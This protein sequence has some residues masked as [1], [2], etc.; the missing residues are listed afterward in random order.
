MHPH[1]GRRGVLLAD[2]VLV[3]AAQNGCH[4]SFGLIYERHAAAVRATAVARLGS[5]SMVADVVQ[6]TFARAF[7]RIHTLRDPT[8]VR[9]WL[10]QITRNAAADAYREERRSR[11]VELDAA[12]EVAD[13]RPGPTA[14]VDAA[15]ALAEIGRMI[16][17]LPP[18]DAIAMRALRASSTPAYEGLAMVLGTTPAHARVIAHRARVRLRQLLIER[19]GLDPDAG[20]P[21]PLPDHRPPGDSDD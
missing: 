20:L 21:D 11:L 3:A 1:G 14:V 12:A 2:S 10:L 15:L 13:D 4:N 5:R 19:W 17:V 6:E 8:L 18:R 9:P 7:V 16:D